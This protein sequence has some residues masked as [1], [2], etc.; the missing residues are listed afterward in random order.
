MSPVASLIPYAPNVQLFSDNAQKIRYFS[1]PNTG[2]PLT[3]S[4]QITYAPTNTWSFPAG[5]VFVKTF[6][7]QTN[8]SDPN[9]LLR[10]ETRLLVRDTN[11]AVYGVTYKWRPITAMPICFPPARPNH[12][13]HPNRQRRLHQPLVLSQPQRLFAVPHGRGQLRAGRQYPAAQRQPD[14]F[15]RRDRQPA[16]RSQPH[17]TCFIPRSTK[18]PSPTSINSPP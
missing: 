16:A 14:L 3:P 5:T 8:T 11:G 1:V 2:A 18:R 4:E 9:S 7:L 15:Q 12:C 6:E 17:R 10:L 13:D